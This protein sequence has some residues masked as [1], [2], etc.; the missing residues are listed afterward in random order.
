[1]L[2]LGKTVRSDEGEFGGGNSLYF[3][4]NVW[5]SKNTQKLRYKILLVGKSKTEN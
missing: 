2:T 5:K 3:L 1:M 4:L